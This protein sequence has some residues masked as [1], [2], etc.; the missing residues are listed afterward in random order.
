M[1]VVKGELTTFEA[2]KDL[3][4]LLSAN[5]PCLSIYM[6]LSSASKEGVNPPYAKEN[7]LNWRESVRKLGDKVAQFGST[8]RDLLNSVSSWDAVAPEAVEKGT[9]PGKSI[10]VF[11]SSDS[12]HVTLLDSQVEDI[13]VLG[14]HFYVRPLLAE[15]CTDHTFYLLAL[16]QRNTRLLRCTMHTS[17]ELSLPGDVKNDFDQWMNQVKP[18]HTAVT[19]AMT[20]GTQGSQGPNALAPKGAYAALWLEIVGKRQGL[21]SRLAQTS[22][23]LD[24]TKW[25]APVVKL[26]LGQLTAD[27]VLASADDPNQTTKNN[28][29]CEANFYSGIIALQNGGK[30]EAAKLFRLAVDGCPKT[31]AEWYGAN[32]ELKALGR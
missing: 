20:G 27:A 10:A 29:V 14:P 9:A 4:T 2:V 18:D 32:A 28:H 26:M 1:H 5:G 15:L 3:K 17:E 16:S 11:R 8:G 6:R 30:D 24:M 21:A 19:N 13:T 22:T 12:F 31:Y 25:P 7:E 23:Q